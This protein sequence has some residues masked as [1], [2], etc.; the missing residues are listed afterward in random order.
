MIWPQKRGED[1]EV[2]SPDVG[3]VGTAQP[4]P[5]SAS[6]LL[7]PQGRAV[8][9]VSQGSCSEWWT[10]RLPP[11]CWKEEAE[12]LEESCCACKSVQRD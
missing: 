11:L 4:P 2:F 1:Q 9:V 7:G 8:L 6:F 10:W 5:A 3:A 12:P